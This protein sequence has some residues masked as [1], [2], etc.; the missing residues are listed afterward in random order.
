MAHN[1]TKLSWAAHHTVEQPLHLLT[2]HERRGSGRSGSR[3]LVNCWTKAWFVERPALSTYWTLETMLITPYHV[4]ASTF[5][6]LTLQTAPNSLSR[7]VI[8]VSRQANV[9]MQGETLWFVNGSVNAAHEWRNGLLQSSTMHR[10]EVVWPRRC[11]IIS[12]EDSAN[13]YSHRRVLQV[14]D[15]LMIG[16]Q[17]SLFYAA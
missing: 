11:F 14:A 7:G 5:S 2:S 9:D 10:A 12:I 16:L 17:Q 6:S 1:D 15:A 8:S 3:F 4:S 13:G